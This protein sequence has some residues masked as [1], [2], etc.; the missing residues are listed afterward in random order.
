[1]SIQYKG[2]ILDKPIDHVMGERIQQLIEPKSFE[3]LTSIIPTDTNIRKAPHSKKYLHMYVQ[4]CVH[5]LVSY[6]ST[7]CETLLVLR[8][9]IR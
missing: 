2:S 9:E 6:N 1:M 7:T 5:V 4:E 8:N 3:S